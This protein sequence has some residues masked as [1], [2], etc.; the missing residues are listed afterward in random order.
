MPL[1]RPEAHRLEADTLVASGPIHD[2]FQSGMGADER[3]GIWV[4]TSY[5]VIQHSSTLS[6]DEA[7]AQYG[8]ANVFDGGRDGYYLTL[9]EA[10]LAIANGCHGIHYVD[11]YNDE[12]QDY[13]V[14]K[15]DDEHTPFAEAHTAEPVR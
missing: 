4:R 13:Y 11:D 2:W 15:D 10:R 8:E 5:G 6:L 1:F 12:Y 3:Q 14:C 7:I 9:D